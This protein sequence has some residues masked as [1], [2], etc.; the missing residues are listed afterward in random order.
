M[1][2][3]STRDR[4]KKRF[5]SLREAAF[6]GLAP[7]GGLFM[8]ESIPQIDVDKL[9]ELSDEG[10]I[11]VAQYVAGLLFADEVEKEKLDRAVAD[12]LDFPVPLVE[13][14]SGVYTLEL[15]HGPTF[16]FK[17]VGA[18]F[19][20]R[21]MSLLREGDERLTILTA[22]SGD[23]GS[24][25]AG[26]FYGVEGI[27]VVVLY[28]DGKVSD[29]QERQMTT[30][31]GNIHPLRVRGDF[32]DCQRVVKE[33]FAHDEFRGSYNVTSANSINIL[34]WLPQSF[35]YFYAWCMWYKNVGV[36]NPMVVTPSGNYG[37][38]ASGM[39]ARRMGL[40]INGFVAAS[41][42]N[43]II[44]YY[45]STGEYLPR[46]SQQTIANAMD[47]GTPSNYE[48]ILDLYDYDETLLR[49]DVKG[50]S[51]SDE[52]IKD[53][54]REI[55]S[56]YGYVSDPHSAVGY[57]AAKEYEVEGFY[58]STA[59]CAKFSE[60]INEALGFEPE[61]PA[62]LAKFLGREKVFTP[63]DATRD[64]VEDFVKKINV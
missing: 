11:P 52:Q 57:L 7:D 29:L 9:L 17:D 63:I 26:G 40:P 39:L 59:H 1:R 21:M 47:V 22:T 35:Y 14:G 62:G 51:C 25:V 61:I 41:N 2:Y 54:I 42:A 58:L 15:F 43:D 44:P 16:A 24:A 28:P 49:E 5:Y 50:Y 12:A 34:R 60:V 53:A 27:D 46:H 8:P 38:I 33:I 3:Y 64:A 37:N 36:K 48:R 45:L 4:E 18:R 56:M 19:M 23:T 32:D 10:F 13:I 6:M 55:Y 31:G 20:G 30:L